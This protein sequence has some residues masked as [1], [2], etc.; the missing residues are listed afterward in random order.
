MKQFLLLLVLTFCTFTSHAT[1]LYTFDND[2]QGFYSDFST[3]D[4]LIEYVTSGGNSGGYIRVIDLISGGGN[5]PIN[6]PNI[7]T[8][9]SSYSGLSFDQLLVTG[10]SVSIGVRLEATNNDIWAY[11]PDFSQTGVWLTEFADFLD[12]SDWVAGV[13]NLESFSYA[14]ENVASLQFIMDVSTAVG[15]V[16]GSLDN[17]IFVSSVDVSE[18][19]F[20][21]ASLLVIS[22]LVLIK[23]KA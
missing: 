2:E 7:P 18:P 4:G 6:I 3:A 21:F 19:A 22:L 10:A 23:R 9:L 13:S 17:V 8:N 20:P 1:I 11:R 15:G 16:E 12:Y 14:I 5:L